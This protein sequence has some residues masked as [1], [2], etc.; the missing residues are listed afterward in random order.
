MGNIIFSSQKEKEYALACLEFAKRLGFIDDSSIDGVIKRC[1][2][3]NK[4]R[5]EKSANGEVVYGL[6]CFSPTQYLDYELTRFKL[7]FVSRSEQAE[8]MYNYCEITK[9]DKKDFYKNN[10]DL[11]TRYEGD[12]FRFR[13]L[14]MIIEKKIRGEQY[15]NEI[16]NILCKF[17]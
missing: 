1:C 14:E 12:K 5:A 8:K 15:E 17:S 9:K 4:K 16:N 13:E 3:E 2:D 6:T 7:D 10:K 11:F